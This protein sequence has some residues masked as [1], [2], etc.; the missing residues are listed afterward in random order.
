LQTTGQYSTSINC[1]LRSRGTCWQCIVFIF[2]ARWFL[3]QSPRSSRITRCTLSVCP[4]V[5]AV[6]NVNSETENHRTF[7]LKRE[8][9][10]V[11]SKWQ[12]SFNVK[13][14]RSR[15]H[16]WIKGEPRVVSAVGATLICLVI[17][18]VVRLLRWSRCWVLSRRFVR[19]IGSVC[20]QL[21]QRNIYMLTLRL[22]GVAVCWQY[23]NS[24]Q[25]IDERLFY[26]LLLLIKMT[27]CLQQINSV[28]W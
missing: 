4:S 8:L 6:P 13:G 16:G 19:L 27:D 21:T 26:L 25:T 11:S 3:Q 14:Q 15:S 1:F 2:T 28:A 17:K 7:K 20:E 10:H 9:S 23:G 22:R 5:C 24:W 18:S 12:S